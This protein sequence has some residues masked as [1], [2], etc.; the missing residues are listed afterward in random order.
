MDKLLDFTKPIKCSFKEGQ[1]NPA[2]RDAA[3]E[4]SYKWKA[5]L[6]SGRGGYKQIEVRKTFSAGPMHSNVLL[7]IGLNG[8][9]HGK[10][11]SR[12]PDQWGRSTDGLNVRLSCNNPVGLTFEQF[13]EINQVLQEAKDILV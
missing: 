8:W 7:V 2:L 13:E 5:K 9:E 1:A 3:L 12:T 6:V 10:H 11:E 4:D